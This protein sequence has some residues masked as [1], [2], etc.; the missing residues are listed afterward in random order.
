MVSRVTTRDGQELLL[1]YL[2]STG[3]LAVRSLAG[4]R[5]SDEYPVT[6]SD[7]I[8]VTEP[9]TFAVLSRIG[10][11]PRC[12]VHCV[13]SEKSIPIPWMYF[14]ELTRDEI[15]A[16]I[17]YQAILVMISKTNTTIGPQ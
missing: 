16:E 9:D 15:R 4:H 5:M 13:L 7:R 14:N 10:D 1:E 2:D 11:G 6:K 3:K 12:V 8:V 17:L